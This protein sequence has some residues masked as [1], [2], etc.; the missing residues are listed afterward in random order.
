[1]ADAT[2]DYGSLLMFAG[3]FGELSSPKGIDL[4][5]IPPVILDIEAGTTVT[6][7]GYDPIMAVWKGLD[8]MKG[9]EYTGMG[10]GKMLELL[11]TDSATHIATIP[12]SAW[13]NPDA[14]MPTTQTVQ[15]KE[16]RDVL[17]LY[18]NMRSLDLVRELP[19]T[20]ITWGIVA[21]AM[22]L[23]RKV[24][25]AS[26]TIYGTIPYAHDNDLTSE[27]VNRAGQGVHIDFAPPTGTADSWGALNDWA[28][29]EMRFGPW[30]SDSN[31]SRRR[32]ST[33]LTMK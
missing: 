5:E 14:D 28:R 22:A 7:P 13:N 26:L 1:M 11:E 19:D 12:Y 29:E 16:R 23:L 25:Y 27:V 17:R 10:I 6:Y 24:R 33:W 20:L 2:F 8:I 9:G 31:E 21:Q 30:V 32:M 3:T 18:V 4:L 15:V